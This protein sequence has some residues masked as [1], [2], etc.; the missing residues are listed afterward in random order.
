MKCPKCGNEVQQHNTS[1]LY[2]LR[3]DQVEVLATGDFIIAF[4]CGVA[5]MTEKPTEQPQIIT[6][7]QGIILP[8]E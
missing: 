4:C 6:Q 1:V 2:G 3:K 8:T 7:P 5:I